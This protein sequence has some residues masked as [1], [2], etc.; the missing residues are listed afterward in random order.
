MED[1]ERTLNS[2]TLAIPAISLATGIFLSSFIK[3]GVAWGFV[4]L[5]MA[6]VIYIVIIHYCRDPLKAY[7]FRL[8]HYIWLA[9]AFIGTGIIFSNIHKPDI[10]SSN[11]S[12]AESIIGTVRD[13]SE[14]ASGDML[15]LDVHRICWSSGETEFFRNLR[16]NVKCVGS[17][18]G[19]SVGDNI[20]FPAT[21]KTIQDNPNSF[22]TGYKSFMH[23]KG[24]F[25]TCNVYDRSICVESH[26]SSLI[27]VSRK[28]CNNIEIYIENTHL[29][30]ETQNFLITV[31][32]GD[33]NYLDSTTHEIFADAGVAH[34]LAL[35]GMHM[36]IIGGMLL[37]ILFPFNFAGKYKTRLMLAAGML[38]I[39]AFIT[40]MAPSTVRACIM[41][42]FAAIAMVLERKKYVF[43]SLFAA[44]LIIL[45]LTPFALFDIGFQLSFVCAA[46]LAAFASHI[47]PFEH[48]TNPKL[49]KIASLFS[50]TIVA[51]FGSWAI[52]AYYFKSFPLAFIPANII[53]LP[54]LPF[55]IVIAMIYLF[56]AGCGLDIYYLRRFLD[57]TLETIKI[58]L[59]WIGNGNTINAQISYETLI[60][61]FTG[62]VLTGLF[63]NVKRWKPLMFSGIILMIISISIIPLQADR[64]SNNSFI[65][66][67]NY[68]RVAINIKKGNKEHLILMDKGK[69][70]NINIGASSITAIDCDLPKK[71]APCK[72]DYLVIAGGYKGNIKDVYE[73][74]KPSRIVIHPS[75][76]RKRENS[77]IIESRNIGIE[78]HSLRLH[79]PLK[80]II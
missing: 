68:Y 43:N 41:V 57:L 10:L 20:K 62:L 34:V 17:D 76:R 13:I 3:N 23:S 27:S 46:S 35:S 6:I 30:K 5:L 7:R 64:V 60:L 16:I 8:S 32:L 65:I 59:E 63:L 79:Q 15:T 78:C 66:T 54:L 9:L 39:Y 24:I 36:G 71:I 67:N 50:A 73:T 53:L 75:V 56:F 47:N 49:Y 33:R 55:Y 40:G 42:S 37:F 22:F 38:W 52:T 51:T 11:N 72:C 25:Y 80:V 28:I 14:K 74:F 2:N 31:L 58:F 12:K 69:I 44:S 77:Y 45:L 61:W 19:C 26:D 29:S 21:I 4:L 18:A 1:L 70:S 48:K